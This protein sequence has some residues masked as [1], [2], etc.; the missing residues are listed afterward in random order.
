MPKGRMREGDALAALFGS[1]QT[2]ASARGA[3]AGA[4]NARV[5]RPPCDVL[6]APHSNKNFDVPF[7]RQT[8]S[9]VGNNLTL[10][11]CALFAFCLC[12]W[13]VVSLPGHRLPLLGFYRACACAWRQDLLLQKTKHSHWERSRTAP[14]NNKT[15]RDRC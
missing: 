9:F 13:W 4:K 3:R 8:D 2:W 12:F 1:H 14:D 10:Y 7:D 15:T 6:A 5:A 11:I